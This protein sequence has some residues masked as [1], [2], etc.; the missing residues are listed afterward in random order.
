MSQLNINKSRFAIP[1]ADSQLAV[2]TRT[3]RRDGGPVVWPPE[4][5]SPLTN[6]PPR[7]SSDARGVG[8]R[9]AVAM[10]VWQAAKLTE[11]CGVLEHQHHVRLRNQ[12]AVMSETVAAAVATYGDSQ[13]NV[14]ETHQL[15]FKLRGKLWTH[16][17]REEHGL[18][19]S[20]GNIERNWVDLYRASSAP[21]R[22]IRVLRREHRYF[23]KSF[24][25]IAELLSNYEIPANSG[26]KYVNLV[27]GFRKLESLK[28]KHMQKEEI[29][30]R[31]ALALARELRRK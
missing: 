1:D 5:G 11:L 2:Q 6:S 26:Q 17:F 13:Q 10:D 21:I 25:R 28:L 4:A 18:Y 23:R 27:H 29:L 8:G 9:T 31:R 14:I 20:I 7:A 15:F 30:Y 19:S 16:M 24:R 12:L 22:A 3:H